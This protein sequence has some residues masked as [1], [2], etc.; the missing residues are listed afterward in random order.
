[1][2]VAEPTD[3]D[4]PGSLMIGSMLWA[5][6]PTPRFAMP[7]MVLASSI[8]IRIV[9]PSDLTQLAELTTASMYGDV[10]LF[11]DGPLAS[12]Q[13]QQLLGQRRA[14]LQRRIGLEDGTA[15][16]RFFVAVQPTE[17]GDRI[18]GSVDS[19]VHL[20]NEGQLHFELDQST[21]PQGRGQYRW[22]PYMASVAVCE[23]DRRSGI[24]TALVR[25]AEA[26]AKELGYEE[27]MLEVSDLN[28]RAL[29]FYGH[30]GYTIVQSFAKGEAGGGGEIVQRQGM[31]WDVVQTGKH[32]MRREL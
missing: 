4:Y 9:E 28:D 21:M 16:C 31:R 8:A 13:R 15:E 12:L 17:F 23:A 29:N 20:F 14:Q 6:L 22:A 3:S 11:R 25:T 30:L 10:D 5:D 1:M 19:A 27:M 24:G 26:W 18:C 32:V 2:L 7:T